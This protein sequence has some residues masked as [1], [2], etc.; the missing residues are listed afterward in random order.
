MEDQHH[1]M[2]DKTPSVFRLVGTINSAMVWSK[3]SGALRSRNLGKA[4]TLQVV[5]LA[6]PCGPR[7][8][9]DSLEGTTRLVST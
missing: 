1:H 3:P 7:S 8:Q 9:Y 6:Q 4:V 5:I 2:R